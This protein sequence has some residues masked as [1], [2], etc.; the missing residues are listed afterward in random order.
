[1]KISKDSPL[2]IGGQYIGVILTAVFLL[3]TIVSVIAATNA[4]RAD[5]IP[6]GSGIATILFGMFT[7]ISFFSSFVIV[8]PNEKVVFSFLGKYR[9]TLETEGLLLK[10]P[11]FNEK[12]VSLKIKTIATKETKIND[13]EGIPLIVSLI[14]NYKVVNAA[15]YVYNSEKPNE[16]VE[17]TC[18]SIL[19]NVVTH[20]A[21]DSEDESEE[22]LSKDSESFSQKIKDRINEELAN[23]GIEVI[24]ARI[25]NISYAPEIAQSMLQ[26]QQ[27]KKVGESRK[28]IVN[29]AIGTVSN[30]VER[31]EKEMDIKFDDSEK[32]RIIRELMVVIVSDQAVTPTINLAEK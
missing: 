18:E 12:C 26:R 31:L 1:M 8:Q 28:E 10:N 20:H 30:A 23:I 22:T 19:R 15:P 29:A 27:A 9:G 24:N 17:N 25:S 32:K 14:V 7:L 5:E 13:K 3:L 21:Y 11:F 4:I 6:I 2:S 16:I